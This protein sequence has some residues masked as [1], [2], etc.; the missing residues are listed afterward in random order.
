ME[1]IVSVEEYRKI[2]GDYS[3]SDEKI[4]LRIQYLESFCRNIIKLELEKY[5]ESAR[6][7]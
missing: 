2:L 3:S 6:Y 5:V 4:T 1:P 7:K